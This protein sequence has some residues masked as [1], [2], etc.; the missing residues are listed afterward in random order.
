MSRILFFLILILP[1]PGAYATPSQVKG[2][3]EVGISFH[4]EIRYARTIKTG[5]QKGEIERVQLIRPL[6][7]TYGA[8]SNDWKRLFVELPEKLKLTPADLSV[9][10]LF[11]LSQRQNRS[12]I[13][14]GP[15]LLG[16]IEKGFYPLTNALFDN[17]IPE[18]RYT[19]GALL[20]TLT[21]KSTRICQFTL[22]TVE[23]GD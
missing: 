21:S 22:E 18:G 20:F 6:G 5:P 12:E 15:F 7:P 1:R 10:I 23:A 14:S 13:K 8:N 19:P 16:P 11:G 3:G 17:L 9:E 4:G 2:C